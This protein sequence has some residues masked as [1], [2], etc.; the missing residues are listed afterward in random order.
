MWWDCSCGGFEIE[1]G[2]EVAPSFGVLDAV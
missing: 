1:A 2:V